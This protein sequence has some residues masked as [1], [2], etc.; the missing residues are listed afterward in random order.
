MYAP[1]PR[2]LLH[3]Q[4]IHCIWPSW[5]LEAPTWRRWSRMAQ[6]FDPELPEIAETGSMNFR[7]ELHA[8]EAVIAG[9]SG[10]CIV[11]FLTENGV[12]TTLTPDCV[13]A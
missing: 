5:N 10:Q 3:H 9:A 4:L 11:A 2:D 7:E 12:C 1:A 6:E 13:V 8:I